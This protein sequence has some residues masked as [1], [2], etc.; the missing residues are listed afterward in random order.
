MAVARSRKV[1]SVRGRPRV[2]EDDDFV[3]IDGLGA[4]SLLQEDSER[5]AMVLQLIEFGGRATFNELCSWYGYDIRATVR[6]LFENGWV[7][8][9]K[10]DEVEP[11]RRVKAHQR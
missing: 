5:R 9:C 2:W 7:M 4:N 8:V 3:C 6:K 1:G 10:P 11:P